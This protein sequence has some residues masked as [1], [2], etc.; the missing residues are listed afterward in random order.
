[1][2][3]RRQW[4]RQFLLRHHAGVESCS[5]DPGNGFGVCGAEGRV[6]GREAGGEGQ[7]GEADLMANRDE[8]R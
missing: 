7:G 6:G 2:A 3:V 1:V 5:L 4:Q 8:M